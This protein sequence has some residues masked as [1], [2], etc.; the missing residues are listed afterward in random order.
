MVQISA[1]IE[2]R[3]L[4]R[5]VERSVA[6]DGL[7]TVFTLRLSPLLPGLPVG[8]GA[9]RDTRQRIIIDWAGRQHGGRGQPC[10]AHVTV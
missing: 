3:P 9:G 8:E 2:K 7:K 5:A 1:Q 10:R 6:R 4:L